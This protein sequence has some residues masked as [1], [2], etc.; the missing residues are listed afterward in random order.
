[1]HQLAG[2]RALRAVLLGAVLIVGSVSPL[3]AFLPPSFDA[4]I[5]VTGGSGSPQTITVPH[6]FAFTLAED[7][8]GYSLFLVDFTAYSSAPAGM[9]DGAI[10]HGTGM[11]FLAS[12][13]EISS[14]VQV[15]AAD[16]YF[17]NQSFAVEFA[18]DDA[19]NFVAGTTLM[20]TAGSVTT[21]GAFA[22]SAPDRTGAFH[23]SV[24][25][26]NGHYFTPTAAAIP[27]P[28]TYAMLLG[29]AALGLTFWR[30]RRA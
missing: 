27:E 22:T 18:F 25:D 26:G 17:G 23:F 20:V 21:D 24:T 5:A 19:V 10:T 7:F 12:T 4:S 11:T 9:I 16:S 15:Y 28:S 29:A 3:R 8:T 30:R 14:G 1:M 6:T 13:S 2:F